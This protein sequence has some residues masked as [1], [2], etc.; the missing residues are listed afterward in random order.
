MAAMDA[1]NREFLR[2][3]LRAAVPGITNSWAM[4]AGNRSP[5]NT[6]RGGGVACS[7]FSLIMTRTLLLIRGY[8]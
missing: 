4:R 7:P 2:N 6:A 1:F 5:C 3:T 8:P